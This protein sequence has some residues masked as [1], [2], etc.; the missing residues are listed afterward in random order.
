MGPTPESKTVSVHDAARMLNVSPT[1]V[2][3]YI[4]TRVLDGA[5][6]QG[7]TWVNY[8]DVCALLHGWK[9]QHHTDWILADSSL[10]EPKTEEEYREASF[11]AYTSGGKDVAKNLRRAQ[12]AAQARARAARAAEQL[13][14]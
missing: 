5:V 11:A 1:D 2:Y 4:S 10:E 12:Y 7:Q 8:S 9:V 6:V 3:D 13:N 14:P